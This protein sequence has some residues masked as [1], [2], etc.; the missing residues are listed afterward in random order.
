MYKNIKLKLFIFR[1]KY[2]C[3]KRVTSYWKRFN[4]L[5]SIFASDEKKQLDENTRIVH[6]FAV[7]VIENR[8]KFL[9]QKNPTDDNNNDAAMSKGMCFVDILLQSTIDDQP[10][11][12]QDILDQ[13]R[14]FM[15]G[16]RKNFHKL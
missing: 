12:D 1:L 5:F 15:I 7:K 16:V 9:L 3:V 4:I 2:I 6:E 8:R 13:M 11:S 14:T 10:L